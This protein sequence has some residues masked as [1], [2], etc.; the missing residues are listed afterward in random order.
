MTNVIIF[1]LGFVI[2]ILIGQF[3]KVNAGFVAIIFGFILNW[4]IVGDNAAGF[5]RLFPVTLFWNYGIPIIFYAFASANGTLQ[6]LGKKIIWKF[7]TQKWAMSLAVLFSAA[8]VAACGAGT[9]N[10]LI[11]APL[12][13]ALCVTAGVPYLLIPFAL[14][15]G[16]FIGSFLPWTSNGALHAA[17]IGQNVPDVVVSTQSWRIFIFYM[18]FAVIV[19]VIAFIALKGWKTRSH[20]SDA[21]ITEP[22]PL[23]K[24]HKQTLTIIVIMIALLLIPLIL[25]TIAPGPV[26]NWMSSNLSITVTSVLGITV[27]SIMK[28]GDI[29]E[30]FSKHV[31]WNII[32]TIT[33]MGMYCALSRGLGVDTALGEWLQ[34]LSPALIAPAVVL[35]GAA[36]SF[37]VSATAVLPMLY[38][39][40][41]VLALA[42]GTSTAAMIIPIAIGVGVTSFSPF[43]VGGATALIGAPTEVSGKMITPMIASAIGMAIFGVI[44][45]FLGLFTVGV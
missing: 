15:C 13:W 11:L 28:L 30:V 3:F 27:L 26:W 44:L 31:N 36:L 34:T 29:R 23:T 16:S 1:F 10:T 35:V 18:V 42:A 45:A 38:S 32:F 9:N 39:L 20:A 17:L 8:V 41:P 4:V 25:K 43:S 40:T 6:A 14:W 12:A 33:G 24:E 7:R 37:V 5:I 2:A 22:E 19:F 21:D